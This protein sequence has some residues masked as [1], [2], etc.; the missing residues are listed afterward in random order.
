MVQRL[1]GDLNGAIASLDL[2]AART[3]TDS[4]P[5][6]LKGMIEQDR[7]NTEA[8]KRS[9]AAATQIDPTGPARRAFE[10]LGGTPA[11]A[12]H[13]DSEKTEE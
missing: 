11:L 3:T 4:T 1:D 7:G 13:P 5:L 6:L 10:S 9:Y 2:A 8:A 12:G